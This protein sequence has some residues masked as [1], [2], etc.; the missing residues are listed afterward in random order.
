M[1]VRT[2]ALLIVLV[3]GVSLCPS[4]AQTPPSSVVKG[5]VLDAEANAPLPDTHVFIAQS[6]NGTVTDSTGHFRLDGVHPGAKRL[7]VSRVGYTNKAVDFQPTPGRTKVF[8][9][10]L[11]PKVLE[12]PPVTISAE[13]DEE[14]YE[15]LNRFK[16]RFIGTT[17]Y[18]EK[19]TLVN[20]EVLRFE[21]KWWGKFKAWTEKP[22]VIKNRALGYRLTYYLKEFEESGTIVRWDGEPLFEPLTPKDSSQAV[23][24]RRNRLEAYQGSLR[25][26]LRALIGDRLDEE[27]FSLYRL[28]R[29]SSLRRTSRTD[30]IPTTRDRIL[31]PGPDSTY[32]LDTHDRLEVIY[33][34]EPESEMYLDWADITQRRPRDY[35]TSQIKLNEHPVHVDPYGEIV[36]PYGATLYRYFAFTVRMAELLPREYE[37]PE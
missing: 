13:R 6:M 7:Y 9:V 21:E 32:L 28:P 25:H 34:D 20:P 35:Q 1:S 16:E 24:W 29:A 10:R 2:V 27:Q 12:S 22:V 31:E 5:R 30:R 33:R 17:G 18:A 23:R 11:E 8:S 4:L 37:P 15:R 26:F 14:W 36:E 19:C 3:G